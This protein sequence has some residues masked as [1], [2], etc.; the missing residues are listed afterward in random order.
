MGA[1]LPTGVRL[2]GNLPSCLWKLSAPRSVLRSWLGGSLFCRSLDPFLVCVWFLI[3]SVVLL[4]LLCAAATGV[5]GAFR[6]EVGRL[7]T[8]F[9]MAPAGCACRYPTLKVV[10]LAAAPGGIQPETG[11]R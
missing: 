5:S 3:G 9:P 10:L 8:A 2:L 11:V 1:V 4:L 6:L 7:L